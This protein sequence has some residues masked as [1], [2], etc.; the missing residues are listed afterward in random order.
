M[1]EELASNKEMDCFK[2]QMEVFILSMNFLI[3]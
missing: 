2:K 1:N 3:C